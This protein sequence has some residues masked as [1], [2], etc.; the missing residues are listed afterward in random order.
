MPLITD[1]KAKTSK[2]KPRIILN[3]A[4]MVVITELS[5]I[6][7]A[8]VPPPPSISEIQAIGS[9]QCAIP[10]EE[11]TEEMLLEEQVGGPSNA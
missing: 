7:D 6:Q 4:S 1:S 2:V 5:K 8:D 11:L 10:P 9:H 3:V